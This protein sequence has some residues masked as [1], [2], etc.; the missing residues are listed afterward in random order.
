LALGTDV[1]HWDDQELER[2]AAYLTVYAR[3]EP[4]HKIRIVQ[5]LRRRGEVVAMTGDGVNDAP[6]L[7]AADIGVAVGAGTEVAKE[8]ADLVLLDNNLATVVAAV[9]QG[10]AIFDNIRKGVVYLLSGSFTEIILIGGSILLDLPLPLLP[11]QILWINLVTDTL[12][13]IALTGEVAE[14]DVMRRRPRLRGEPVLNRWTVTLMFMVGFIITSTL[15]AL[16]LW[17]TETYQDPIRVHSIMF[18]ALGIDSLLYVYALRSL[19]R[20]FLNTRPFSN[21]LLPVS[22]AL[23]MAAMVAALNIPFL[24]SVFDAVPLSLST[25][26]VLLMMGAGKLAVIEIVKYFLLVRRQSR[27]IL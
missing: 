1:D 24:L 9:E 23:G 25:W 26:G 13:S 5:A 8:S 20:P 12:P 10:R 21:P 17:A 4:K 22:V 2:R 6:A 11:L 14:P 3:T 15:F 27:S 18:A 19:S 16:F 7:K